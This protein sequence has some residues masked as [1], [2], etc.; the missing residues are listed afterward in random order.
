M[1][2]LLTILIAL[3]LIAPAT[4]GAQKT[5]APPGNAG[6]D[7]YLETVPAGTGNKRVQPK[8][9]GRGSLPAK[10]VRDLEAQGPDGILA[11]ELA[12]ATTPENAKQGGGGASDGSAGPGVPGG[13]SGP[14]PARADGGSPV[15]AVVEAVVGGGGSGGMGPLLPAI[16]LATLAVIVAA[17]L[18][19]RRASS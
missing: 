18:A 1:P 3:L 10:T 6:I 8:R 17:G 19:R 5:N 4:A 12:A 16:L 11:A 2:R 15:S 7:E 13:A 9:G 14:A